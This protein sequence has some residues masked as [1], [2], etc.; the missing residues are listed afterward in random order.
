MR[1]LLVD[2]SSVFHIGKDLLHLGPGGS[3]VSSSTVLLRRSHQLVRY[4][5]NSRVGDVT[6]VVL[7]FTGCVVRTVV[8][9]G[10]MW[11]VGGCPVMPVS[12]D[13]ADFRCR[14]LNC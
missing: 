8:G 5:F 10:L 1:I 9:V 6:D 12:F 3:D 2:F 14:A 4:L 11:V 13:V 7:P